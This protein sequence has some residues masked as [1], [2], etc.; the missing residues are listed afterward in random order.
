[1]D[2]PNADTSLKSIMVPQ[3]EKVRFKNSFSSEAG[4]ADIL[5]V[6]DGGN[7]RPRQDVIETG[8]RKKNSEAIASLLE[9]MTKAE[10]EKTKAIFHLYGGLLG[11]FIGLCLFYGHEACKLRKDKNRRQDEQCREDEQRRHDEQH[12]QE[13]NREQDEQRC[14]RERILEDLQKYYEDERQRCEKDEQRLKDTAQQR[15]A[16]QKFLEEMNSIAYHDCMKA[17]GLE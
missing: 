14:Q 2:K 16:I 10:E 8:E 15:N 17:Q 1:M 11:V 4:F 6:Y 13:E 7:M 12:R 3:L 5:V 9:M